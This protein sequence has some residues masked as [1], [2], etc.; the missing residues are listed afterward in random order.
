MEF[1]DLFRWYLEAVEAAPNEA[2]KADRFV[3]FIRRVFHGV[4]VGPL[5]GYYPDLDRYVKYSGHGRIIKGK[6]LILSLEI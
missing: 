3:D 1:E 4:D 6:N 5:G 2:T